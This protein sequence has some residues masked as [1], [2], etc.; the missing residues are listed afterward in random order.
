MKNL[1]I[2]FFLLIS[3]LVFST[4]YYVKTG[5]SDVASGLS[6]ALAWGTIDK[7]N[8]VWAAGTFAPADSI[9]FKR[10]DSFTGTITP[11]ESG[12]AGNTIV[13]GS[14]GTGASP[15][16]NGFTTLSSW[17]NVGGGVYSKVV[18]CASALQ[19]VTFDGVNTPM[20]RYPD[21]D[22]N[23]I[24]SHSSNTALTDATHLNSATLNWTGA[25][26]VIR[27]NRYAINHLPITG[28]SGGTLT[29]STGTVFEPENGWGYFIQKDLRTV[30]IYK[31]WYYNTATS[32]FYMYF[33]AENPNDHTVKVAAVNN[34]INITGYGY[35]TIDSLAITGFNANG[36]ILDDAPHITVQ[37]STISFIG[38]NGINGTEDGAATSEYLLV[39]NN[40]IT[41]TNNNT[42]HIYSDSYL[43][44]TDATISNNTII[45]IGLI[46][47]CG[48]SKAIQNFSGIRIGIAGQDNSGSVVQYNSIINV[49]YCGIFFRGTNITI[50]NNYINQF[51]MI[52]DDGG[53]IYTYSE[54]VYATTCSILNNIVL[55][56]YGDYS[57]TTTPSYDRCAAGMYTDGNETNGITIDGNTFANGEYSP[58]Y[59]TNSNTDGVL[60]DNTFY[61][62][63]YQFQTTGTGTMTGL[64]SKRNL[65]I[66][67][68]VEYNSCV[69]IYDGISGTADF[70]DNCYARPSDNTSYMIYWDP[71]AAAQYYNL[72]QWKSVTSQDANSRT[73]V[74]T[75]NSDDSLHFLYNETKV[76]KTFT[77]SS[78]MVDVDGTVYSGNIIINPFTSLVLIGGGT[79]TEIPNTTATV[80]TTTGIFNIEPTTATGGG[81][82]S[83]DGGNAVTDRG[84]CWNTSTNPTT[85]NSHTHDGTGEGVY[86]S[87]LT[88]LSEAT[89]YYVRAYAINSDGTTYGANVTFT[90]GTTEIPPVSSSGF[91]KHDD[92]FLKSGNKFIKQ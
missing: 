50:N 44:F 83:D 17:T 41:E 73:T 69:F 22:W 87:S 65:F 70:D 33:G 92:K 59:F 53:G 21:S 71:P 45:N 76:D 43:Q 67:K 38:G 25:E 31:E 56:G 84:V 29:Y 75:V 49:G 18:T 90:S 6:D 48:Y 3:Q 26:V 24:I 52:M 91:M 54:A 60:T 4:N 36:I 42:I 61:G 55:N 12:T 46:R 80:I 58:G 74:K 1:F 57:G 27:V 88:G 47:G 82:V 40:T 51:C 15:I 30:T 14:Y 23:T 19:M 16:I 32:T 7:V 28:H 9:L 78:Q 68:G 35:I 89:F 86:E 39:D 37:G 10:G 62:N 8:T 11:T 34:G 2:I 66:A 5:G 77:L 72:A 63:R 79:T 85:S 81:N 64:E 13:I 20:G